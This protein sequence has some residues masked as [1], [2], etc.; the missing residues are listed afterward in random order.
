MT[1]AERL[2][3]LRALMKER[4]LAA[5]IVPTDDFHGSE[6]VGEY[7]KA[8]AYLAGFTGSAGT[9]VVLRDGAYLWTD[10]RYFLQ[11]Q[12]QLKGSTVELM[13]D[14]QPGVPKIADF[15]AEHLQE[16]EVIGFDGRTVTNHFV[17]KI[18]GKTDAKQITF[19]GSEDLAGMVW[20]NRPQM[21]AE[22]VWE[23]DAS[24]AGLTREEK[25]ALLREKMKQE[26][27]DVLVLAALDEIAWLLNLRGNDVSCTPVFLSYMIIEQERAFLCVQEQILSG[28]IRKKL[29]DAGIT[30]KAYGAVE[31]ILQTIPAGKTVLADGNKVN[32][33]LVNSIPKGAVKK[34]V[35]SPV[36]RMKAI[37][38]PQEMEHL[39][40]AH[41][42]DGVA[43]TKFIYWLKTHVGQEK[44]TELSAAEK[45][46]EFRKQ[47]EG[48]VEPSF[49]PIIAYGAHG[50]IIHYSATEESNVQMQAK[51]L[52]L[53]DT[54]GHYL[55]GSTDITRT[56]SL[57]ELTEEEKRIY[58]LVLR[59]HLNLAAVRFPHGICGANLDCLARQPLWEAGLDYNHGTGHGVGYLLSV[60]EDPQRIRWRIDGNG[61]E[62]V[63]E[64]GMLISNEPGVYLA[65]K[66]GVRVESLVLCRKD[67]ETEFG[68]FL[69]FDTLTVVPF[70]RA[71][72]D[73]TLLT[74]EERKNLN[75]Y[76][77]RVYK[78]ISPYLTEEER[79]WLKEE[80]KTLGD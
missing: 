67:E 34:D 47:Q 42:K 5:Y 77:E 26:Q 57:G 17:E 7:F 14:G 36:V 19:Y 12:D 32:Y 15:L 27:A 75:A 60:H 55:E 41:I 64:E 53:A 54:G 20:E 37:K 30:I 13:K 25:L 65:N 59:G 33:Q 80:T 62:T 45:L 28:E 56:I 43:V 46:E 51:S 48:Y 74:E 72:I 63:L 4:N 1:I 79:A 22:P 69:Y 49:N 35:D 2:E 39:R 61:G 29:E 71:A 73:V 11:A 31:E 38:T 58:T 66:F 18:A 8:R 52:C 78:T 21:S 10:G 76:H 44:I 70:D 16:K 23:L 3:A 9:L 24:Y 68:T 50:A 6:Y 40:A